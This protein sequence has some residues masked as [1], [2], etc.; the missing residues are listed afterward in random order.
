MEVSGITSF[1]YSTGYTLTID[2]FMAATPVTPSPAAAPSNAVVTTTTGTTT[3]TTTTTPSTTT[4]PTTPTSTPTLP[5]TPAGLTQAQAQQALQEALALWQAALGT[6]IHLTINIVVGPAA[7]TELGSAVITGFNQNGTPAAGTIDITSTAQGT[8][9]FVDLNPNDPAAFDE[10]LNATASQASSGAASREYDLL[11]AVSH[12]L[13]HLLGFT[14]NDPLFNAR[15]VAGTDGRPHFVT[16]D[17]NLAFTSDGDHLAAAVATYDLMNDTLTPGTRKLPSAL[18]AKVLNEINNPIIMTSTN[19][20]IMGVIAGA[21]QLVTGTTPHS[22]IQNG[23]FAITDPNNAGFGWAT[24]GTVTAANNAATLTESAGTLDTR[25]TQT[26]LIPTTPTTLSF[27]I[28]AA[29]LL[30]NNGLPPDAFEAAL[31]DAQSGTNLLPALSLSG[32]DAFLNLQT[33]GAVTLANGVTLSAAIANGSISLSSPITVTLDIHTLTPGEAVTLDFD[34]LGFAPNASSISIG[35]VQLGGV[36]KAPLTVQLAPASDTGTL[37]DNITNLPTVTI[38]GITNPGQVVTLALGTDGFTDGTTTADTN[39]NYSFTNVPL[40]QGPNLI[41]VKA[42]NS[43]GDTIGTLTV[44]RDSLAPTLTTFLANPGQTQR[45]HLFFAATFSKDVTVSLNAFSLFLVNGTTFTPV[46]LTGATLSYSTATHTATLDLAKVAL[47]DGNYELRMAASSVSDPAGN[48]LNLG[49]NGTTPYAAVDT[50]KLAGDVNGDGVV[51][52]HDTLI[53]RNAL[54]TIPGQPAF[55]INA[56]LDNNNVVNS[57]DLSIVTTN[58]THRITPLT[59]PKL[60]ILNSANTPITSINFGTLAQGSP[61]SQSI[62]LRNDGQSTLTVGAMQLTGTNAAL[63]TLTLSGGLP[64]TTTFTLAAGQSITL[65][66]TLNPTTQGSINASLQLATNDPTLAS[67]FKMALSAQVTPDVAP[68]LT[69]FVAN[70]GQTQRSHLFF[71]ATFSKDVTV[72]L[73]AFSL[74]LVNGTTFT[75]VS[76]AGA[77]LTYAASTHTA[78]LDLAKVALA[79]GNYELRLA[80]ASVLDLAGTALNLGINGTSPYAAVDTFKLAGD[81]NGDGVVDAHDTLIVRNALN[82]TPGQPTFNINADLDGSNAVDRADLSIVTTNL[83]HRITPL[84]APKLTI[85]NSANAPVTSINFGTPAQG[86]AASTQTIT[87]RNDGQS[88]LTVGALQLTGTNAGLFGLTL[89]GSLPNTTTFTLASGQSITL[90]IAFNPKTAGAIS[91]ALQ[92]VTNDP[93]LA[94]PVKIVLSAQ[95]TPDVPPTLTTFLANPGQTQRSHLFFTATFSKDVTVGLNAFSLFLVNGTTFTPVSLTGATLSY[96]T[97]THTATLDLAKL[98]LADG[99]YELRMAAACVSDA[100][101]STLNLGI[102]GITPYAAVD[103]FKLAGDVNG[104][105]IVDAHDT[106][107]VRNALNTTPG[108]PAFNINA[109]L[110]ASNAVNSTDLALVTSNLAHRITPLTAPKL[111]I[112]NSANTPITS[113]NFGTLA[114]GSTSVTQ[115]VTLRNDGQSTL[116]V[117]ALQLTGTN[118]GLFTLTLSGGLPKTTTFTLAAGQSITL[119][120]TLNPSTS[121]T[122][123]GQLQLAVNDPRFLTPVI[124]QLLAQITKN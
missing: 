96:S 90:T 121:G 36:V 32:T 30:A 54:N 87:L 108:Q 22:T 34:L 106:L 11:T 84:T 80:A 41:R 35:N 105:G 74:F 81:V 16:S 61:A 94:T 40:T 78:T 63:F 73:S 3:T 47:A 102:N 66:I 57:G 33:G 76:L 27:T 68:T 5:S 69:S 6:P 98:K 15:I 25:L 56:D 2:P 86:A 117:G 8:P 92:L 112:L 52:A 58:L 85:L 114:Q 24:T 124:M 79:D 46:S 83:T 64:K 10:S 116:T 111:T 48:T 70:P 120:L 55:N 118:A 119:T 77:T 39:G 99:N 53:V 91:A 1:D 43:A 49:I 75:P 62:T 104:D 37:G 17:L 123:A 18:D 110:D 7:G 109:D 72:A 38:A 42:T 103:T 51:D 88:T 65:T 67:P 20:G 21:A 13:G 115:T 44:T 50:F 45:S 26:F 95:V 14:R 29:N 107:I 31:V 12:E 82:T 97:A 59:A 9:W 71:A 100:A 122:I 28:T 23:T 19:A 4:T 113:I 93:T 89:S 60:T 101:G